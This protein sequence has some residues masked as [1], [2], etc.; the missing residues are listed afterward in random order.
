MVK[1]KLNCC[2]M[3]GTDLND[4]VIIIQRLNGYDPQHLRI[5]DDRV[6]IYDKWN[7]SEFP[8]WKRVEINNKSTFGISFTEPDS[9]RPILFELFETLCR[10]EM[11]SL[12]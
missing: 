2:T 8:E 7:D 1:R 3:V 10:R 12:T 5:K 9:Y 6:W 11:T 4:S